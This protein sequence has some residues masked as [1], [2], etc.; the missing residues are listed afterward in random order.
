MSLTSPSLR[1][2]SISLA[3]LESCGQP[4]SYV[5]LILKCCPYFRYYTTH[6]LIFWGFLIK[7]SNSPPSKFHKCVSAILNCIL[8]GCAD[9]HHTAHTK[10]APVKIPKMK[11][12]EI[13]FLAL[14]VSF[15][16]ISRSPKN[17]LQRQTTNRHLYGRNFTFQIKLAQFS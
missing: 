9:I 12:I 7:K 6:N 1:P 2:R 14:S 5:V 17:F 4:L 15:M 10:P 3:F 16:N 11:Q 8:L 13:T